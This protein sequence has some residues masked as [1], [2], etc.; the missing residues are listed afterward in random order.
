[1]S[2]LLRS[3]LHVLHFFYHIFAL[4]ASRK[5]RPQPHALSYPRK[6]IPHHLA[7]LLVADDD[8]SISGDAVL[9]CFL[10]S[11]QRT[12]GWC[13]TV[14]IGKLTVYDRNGTAI[15]IRPRPA[16]VTNHFTGLLSAN[17]DQVSQRLSVPTQRCSEDEN[18]E[19]EYPL[20]PPPSDV[21]DS[22]P[23]SPVNLRSLNLDVTVLEVHS[24]SPVEGGDIWGLKQ[25]RE[26]APGMVI[27]MLF[28]LVAGKTRPK[29]EKLH[30]DE[31]T[32]RVISR[33]SGKPAVAHTAHIMANEPKWKQQR[34]GIQD[35]NAILEGMSQVVLLRGFI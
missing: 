23:L 27:P 30:T 3:L 18:S 16:R 7:L 2:F 6:Q 25:R 35:L 12:V 1:M 15:S 31:I 19:I 26:C 33:S 29:S 13:Q 9:E 4:V 24:T 5:S 32:I 21:C 11:V 8:E 34:I 28:N 22:R 14:G 20:T 17:I 10:E